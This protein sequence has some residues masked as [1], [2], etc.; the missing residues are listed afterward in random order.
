MQGLNEGPRS[1]FTAEQITHLLTGDV[2]EVSGGLRLLDTSNRL[3]EDISDDL[4]GGEV[5][6]DNLA[7]IPG[8]CSLQINRELAWGKDRVQPYMDLSNS[9]ITARFY[10]GIFVLT[11]PEAPRGESPATY[12]VQGYD[13]THLLRAT[14]PGDTYSVVPPSGILQGVH[15]IIAASG[16]NSMAQFDGNDSNVPSAM[17]WALAPSVTPTWLT[18]A[19]DLLGSVGYDPLWADQDGILRSAPHIDPAGR[20]VEW[21][22]DTS[23]PRVNIVG[24][25]R[26]MQEEVWGVPNKWK[27]VRRVLTPAPTEGAGIYT[28]TNQS[29]GAS[30]IDAVG[31][32]VWRV[33]YLDVAD[34]ASLVAQGD[35]IVADDMSQ[36]RTFTIKVDPLPIAMHRDVVRLIDAGRDDRCIVK[37]WT[38]PL[39]GSQGTWVLEVL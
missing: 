32:E 18:I 2:L 10:L 33:E 37:S 16:V 35:R 34:H 12:E 25:D 36:V 7:E 9:L 8:A 13:T 1:A 17:V 15:D 27:F 23:N 11:T 14:G 4:V 28:V 22:F 3:V 20:G 31:R 24:E 26:V 30:S 38:L 21:V 19:N 39:D 6:H 29:D 5:T